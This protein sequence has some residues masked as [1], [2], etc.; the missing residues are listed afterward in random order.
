MNQNLP[1]ILIFTVTWG[2]LAALMWRLTPAAPLAALAAAFLVAA[3]LCPLVAVL[4][5]L[6]A[7]LLGPL[8]HL[9]R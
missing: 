4:A 7:K 2:G 1:G 9:L 8:R 3:V 5:G 6:F